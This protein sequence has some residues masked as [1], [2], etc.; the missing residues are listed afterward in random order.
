MKLFRICFF[1]LFFISVV[2]QE[3]KIIPKF[4][5]STTIEANEFIDS[6]VFGY[7]YYIKNNIF[8]KQKGS[9]LFQYKNLSLGK[10]TKV[11]SQNPLKIILFYEGFNTVVTLDNQLSESQIVSF[12]K[13]STTIVA[14][15]VGLA[16]QNRLWVFNSLTMQLGLYDL[17]KLTH[18]PLAQ[19]FQ[20]I[21]QYYQ[22]DFNHFYW[23]ED[24]QLVYSCD[25][26]GKVFS[27]GKV[28]AFTSIQFL[29]E[30]EVIYQWENNLYYYNLKEDKS[31]LIE[32][33]K[34]TFQSFRF[35]D[36]FLIIFTDNEISTYQIRLP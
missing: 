2:G 19:P 5:S 13:N 25:V 15:A 23:I 7:H 26:Y 9:E 10:I 18:Q 4:V 21:I 30:K 35:K 14:T 33:D 36:Q 28:P 29:S 22:A 17:L 16:S 8:Y 12:S 6:D 34:K 31:T 3:K 27:L 32:L 11:D 1:L 24:T 20:K